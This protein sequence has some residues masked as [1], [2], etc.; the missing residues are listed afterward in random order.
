MNLE[1][2][3]FT[4]IER[5]GGCCYEIRPIL[6][7]IDPL[8]DIEFNNDRGEYIVY[9]NSGFFQSVKH[10]DFDRYTIEHI[11]DVYR[12]NFYGDIIGEIEAHNEKLKRSEE[13]SRND[14]IQEMAKDLR[15]AVLKDI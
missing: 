5:N 9:F 14:M 11:A 1:N 8:F 15:K 7:E 12:L 13:S 2:A 6:Q 4:G 10:E 3:Q